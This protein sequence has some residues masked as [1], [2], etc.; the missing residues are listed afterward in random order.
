[1]ISNEPPSP[2]ED[3]SVVLEREL[4]R[5]A[6]RGDARGKEAKELRKRV[7]ELEP[8]V[9]RLGREVIKLRE[10]KL[11]SRSPRKWSP[12]YNPTRRNRTNPQDACT[13]RD[14]VKVDENRMHILEARCLKLE[15]EN[16][17][18]KVTAT[19]QLV[20]EKADLFERQLAI[21]ERKV[22]NSL[23]IREAHEGLAAQAVAREREAEARASEYGRR[24]DRVLEKLEAIEQR[25]C[26]VNLDE[27][28]RKDE[29][30]V[31][32]TE[33]EIRAYYLDPDL[34][35]P[36]S[37]AQ[38]RGLARAEQRLLRLRSRLSSE[39]ERLSQLR[40]QEALH[41]ELRTAASCGDIAATHRLLAT[42]VSV[43]VPDKC[44]FSAFLYSCG[45][46]NAELVR[47]MLEAGG[48]VHDGNGSITAL[49]IAAKKGNKDV[50]EALLE[51]GADVIGQDSA[52]G[53]ALH[54]AAVH[55]HEDIIRL[56]LEAGAD[57]NCVDQGGNTTLHMVARAKSL[58][59][60]EG[61]SGRATVIAMFL[62][63]WGASANIKNSEDL[64]PLSAALAA[65]NQSVVLAFQNFYGE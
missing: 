61:G 38:R 4:E 45:Q 40:S 10:A 31:H 25:E 2:T 22:Q 64:T 62:L 13:P 30:K 27:A 53:T 28:C 44:G 9:Q 35:L 48:D 26:L 52:G 46:S 37:T 7:Q 42:G 39:T 57:I 32:A 47:L 29:D 34:N 41:E 1:V 43:N 6:R 11:A 18:L 54:A 60:I 3:R 50:V 16:N 5:A 19:S 20:Q 56:L 51:G 49:I 17:D 65:R 14:C 12:R 58:Q 15:Q 59:A 8:E 23:Y 33:G 63:E 24:L 36:V 21:A 55:G